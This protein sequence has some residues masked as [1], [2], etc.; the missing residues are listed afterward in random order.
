MI[1]VM[2]RTQSNLVIT[3]LSWSI[4]WRVVLIL[5]PTGTLKY[6][7]YTTPLCFQHTPTFAIN[8][9]SAWDFRGSTGL[10]LSRNTTLAH[11]MPIYQLLGLLRTLM[12]LHLDS[13]IHHW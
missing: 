2:T 6:L 11:N 8:P 7:E 10:G 13:L 4:L 3:S 12:T 1:S 9:C 5:T